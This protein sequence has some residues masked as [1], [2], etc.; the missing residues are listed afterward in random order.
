MTVGGMQGLTSSSGT[1]LTAQH[2]AARL[3]FTREHRSWQDDRLALAVLT[4]QAEEADGG[5]WI[6]TVAAA[7]THRLERRCMDAK[8]EQSRHG[9]GVMSSASREDGKGHERRMTSV[10]DRQRP[11]QKLTSTLSSR[12][13]PLVMFLTCM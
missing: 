12:Q 4:P 2:C 11:L 5:V 1:A 8:E 10:L 3:A 7:L 6:Q 13:P 9:D